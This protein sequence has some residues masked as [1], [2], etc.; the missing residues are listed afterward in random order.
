MIFKKTLSLLALLLAGTLTLSAQETVGYALID[1]QYLLE[2][3]PA[4][5]TANDRIQNSTKNWTEELQTLDSQAEKLFTEYQKTKASLSPAERTARENAI[6]EVENKAADLQKKYF[7]PTGDLA[8]LQEN[9]LEPIRDKIYEAVKLIS[10]RRGYLIVFDRASSRGTIV[11]ADPMA[12][13]S[14]DVLTVLGV[15]VEE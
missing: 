6:L 8:R 4:Y 5:R 1:M 2:S 7:G 9:L 13:I 10:E 14:N 15:K 12:D 3:L 11:F